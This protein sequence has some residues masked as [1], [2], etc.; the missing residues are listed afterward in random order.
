MLLGDKFAIKNS[1]PSRIPFTR[2][3][4]FGLPRIATY[5][6]QLRVLST[7]VRASSRNIKPTVDVSPGFTY[8]VL[9]LCHPTVLPKKY[10]KTCCSEDCIILKKTKKTMES[11]IYITPRSLRKTRLLLHSIHQLF[12]QHILLRQ[13]HLPFYLL[14]PPFSVLFFTF[15]HSARASSVTLVFSFSCF[16]TCLIFPH[17]TFTSCCLWKEIRAICSSDTSVSNSECWSRYNNDST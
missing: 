14:F 6:L 11:H 1:W 8:L 13:N 9:S 3:V 10:S 2:T 12:L 16:V 5:Y 7:L 17:S 4:L 15:S